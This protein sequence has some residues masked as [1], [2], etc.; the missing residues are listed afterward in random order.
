MTMTLIE[1]VTVGAAGAFSIEFTN[2]PQ[3]GT[4]LLVLVSARGSKSS[5]A[6]DVIR[7]NFNSITSNYFMRGFGGFNGN[8]FAQSSNNSAVISLSNVMPTALATANTFNSASFYVANYTVA[9]PKQFLLHANMENNNNVVSGL[10]IMGGRWND[11]AAV[12]SIRIQTDSNFVQNTTASL[13]KITK[14]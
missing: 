2:I 4:D 6:N 9:E 1:T 11:T 3:D 12:T 5:P 13:Y 8:T 7:F 10:G 14:A